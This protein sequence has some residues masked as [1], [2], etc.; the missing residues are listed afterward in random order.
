MISWHDYLLYLH[1][2]DLSNNK[3]YKTYKPTTPQAWITSL[4]GELKGIA[5]LDRRV[6]TANPRC[7]QTLQSL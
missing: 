2:V 1:L 4:D 3:D 5:E 6:F 7:I